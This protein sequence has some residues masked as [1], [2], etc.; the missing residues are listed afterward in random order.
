[1]PFG[2]KLFVVNLG[3]WKGLV[4]KE[5]RGSYGVGLWKAIRLLW[6]IVSSRTLFV[7]GNGRRVKFW[8]DR[9]CG[10]EP[11][12]VSFPSLFTLASSKEAW[13]A[14]LIQDKVVAE[15]REDEVFR[16]VTKSGSFSVKSLYSILEEVRVGPFP[17]SIVWNAKVPP[18]ARLLWELLFSLFRVCWVIHASIRET[19]LRWHGSF[20]GRK[21]M[22][23]WRAAPLLDNLEGEK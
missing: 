11:L 15:E 1:M 4:L 18:K 21:R 14:N 7:V 17:T 12:C 22:K 6:E 23:V 16:E 3:S 10:D 5:V 20:I 9:W 13:V 8:R 2:D 19:L